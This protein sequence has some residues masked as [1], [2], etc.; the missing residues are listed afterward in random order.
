[1]S[2]P[3]FLKCERAFSA[4]CILLL[5]LRAKPFLMRLRG[6]GLWGLKRLPGGLSQS[7]SLKKIKKLFISLKAMQLK[8]NAQ[9]LGVN[10]DFYLGDTVK[11]LGKLDSAFD[12]IYVDPPY[13]S[14]LYDG[15]LELIKSNNLLKPDGILILEHPK[16]LAIN[17]DGF[18]AIKEKIYADKKLTCLTPAQIH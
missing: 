8:S 12:V 13:Q 17:T 5:I 11:I 9:Q 4:R 14:G 16:D 10:A 15:V 3:R 2:A 18:A 1:M 7:L 6:R